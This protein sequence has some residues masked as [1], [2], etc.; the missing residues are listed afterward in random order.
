MNEIISFIAQYIMEPVL[1]MEHILPEK[2]NLVLVYLSE[3]KAIQ[4][5]FLKKKKKQKKGHQVEIS[6]TSPLIPTNLKVISTL[7]PFFS[8][9]QRITL[10]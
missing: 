5:P 8:G 2:T 4:V 3:Q 1:L 6:S 7:F 10:R 9:A